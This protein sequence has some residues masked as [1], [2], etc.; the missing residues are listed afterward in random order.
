VYDLQRISGE[1]QEMKLNIIF[2]VDGTLDDFHGDVTPELCKALA[3]KGAKLWMLSERDDA[4]E[5]GLIAAKYGLT[6]IPVLKEEN[7][8]RTKTGSLK[9]FLKKHRSK[10]I[11][12]YVGDRAEDFMVAWLSKCVYCAPSALSLEIFKEV[13]YSIGI[14][15]GGE[16]GTKSFFRINLEKARIKAII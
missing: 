1:I 8:L 16:T 5:T 13:K 2:D 10:H 6:P 9:E 7:Y 4:T 15:C 11:P 14:M 12:V 3:A